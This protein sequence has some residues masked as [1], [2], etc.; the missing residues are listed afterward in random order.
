MQIWRDDDEI[1][2][3]PRHYCAKVVQSLTKQKNGILKKCGT[4]RL[5]YFCQSLLAMVWVGGAI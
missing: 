2:E 3:L 1:K 4:K 5:R